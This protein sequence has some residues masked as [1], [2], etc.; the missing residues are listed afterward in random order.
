M[1][2]N[3]TVVAQPATPIFSSTTPA[4]F[5][6]GC[7]QNGYPLIPVRSQ[8]KVPTGAG[9]QLRQQG[10][11]RQE[12][13]PVRRGAESTGILGGELCIVD[14]DIENADVAAAAHALMERCLGSGALVR[15][16]GNS[17]KRAALYR[18]A[19]GIHAYRSVSGGHGK[20]EILGKAKQLVVHGLHETGVP[21]DWLQGGPD[22]FPMTSL[23][24]VTAAQVSE[25]LDELK[26]LL[27]APKT[28]TTRTSRSVTTSALSGGKLP[29]ALA[30]KPAANM[31]AAAISK[32]SF[33][34]PLPRN[35]QEILLRR[36]L[37]SIPNTEAP[38]WSHWKEKIGFAIFDATKGWQ[39]QDTVGRELF[40]SFSRKNAAYSAARTDQAWDEIVRSPPSTVKVGTLIQLALDAGANFHDLQAPTTV[41][42]SGP[43][44]GVGSTPPLSTMPY[45]MP[46]EQ[47]LGEM[48][49]RFCFVAKFGG[50]PSYVAFDAH[51]QPQGRTRDEMAATL[52]NRSVKLPAD[53]DGNTQLLP[54]FKW[55]SIQ[56]GRLAYDTKLYDPEN[57]LA[58]PGEVVLNT[59]R[60]LAMQPTPGAW[61]LMEAHLRHVICG[62]DAAVFDYCFNWLAH[63]VQRP[64]TNPE[65]AL[66]FRSDDEGTGKT[67]AA[68][69]GASW[70]GPH[71]HHA[72]G[73]REIYGEFNDAVLDTSYV[74][75]DEAPNPA[76]FKGVEAMRGQITA[77]TLWV[78]PKGSKAFEIPNCLH[79]VIT[80]NS[81]HA[82]MAGGD[83]RR[84]LVLDVKEKRDRAYF[85][86]LYAEMHS[87]GLA[88]MLAALLAVDLS[89]F[90]PRNIPTTQALI[91][92][93]RQSADDLH[94]WI[95]HAVLTGE[96]IPGDQGNSFNGWVRASRLYGAY[97]MWAQSMGIRRP[98]P[99]LVLS[100]WLKKLGCAPRHLKAGNEWLIPGA[101]ALLAAADRQAGIRTPR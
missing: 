66:V 19:E 98:K 43:A 44:A 27:G 29:R 9:W 14:I 84:F 96:L 51:G 23:P 28:K 78:N 36:A 75:L 74:I 37:G 64:G 85:D 46:P 71:A 72:T 87:G 57:K 58:A 90:N 73:Y 99:V 7:L 59:W 33:Y 5:R 77:R 89:G 40:H 31:N 68:S 63:A 26:P 18:Y 88:A 16:R 45:V 56:P 83:S 3:T 54:L 47:A 55:W 12:L 48:N 80:T 101:N 65:T 67:T 15:T 32:P 95:T 13:L 24:K 20:V 39:D 11:S 22:T 2:A 34:D 50:R 94:Q 6:E 17:A 91:E 25:M 60:G 53:K 79:L 69:W 8:S 10:Y 38:D 30:V 82:V 49:A 4:D 70:L 62:N 81:R 97:S 92:Q 21:Y 76:D 41:V 52:A 1:T 35:K 86:A 61:P 93:Q 42:V 100:R